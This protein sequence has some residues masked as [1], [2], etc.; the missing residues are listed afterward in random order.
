[1]HKWVPFLAQTEA[2][3]KYAIINKAHRVQCDESLNILFIVFNSIAY[4]SLWV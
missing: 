1:M 4:H 2:K 3:W